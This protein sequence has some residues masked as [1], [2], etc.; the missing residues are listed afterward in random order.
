MYHNKGMFQV[1]SLNN[2]NCKRNWRFPFPS[3][4]IS[5]PR[6]RTNYSVCPSGERLG[7]KFTCAPFIPHGRGLTRSCGRA[8]WV[9]ASCQFSSKSVSFKNVKGKWKADERQCMISIKQLS[10]GHR[11]IEMQ[12]FPKIIYQWNFLYFQAKITEEQG[13]LMCQA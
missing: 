5:R 3:P 10:L 2:K 6:P 7:R 4:P 11:L 9:L 12:Y 1:S 13:T 8:H